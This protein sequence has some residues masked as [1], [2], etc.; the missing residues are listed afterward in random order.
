MDL[1]QNQEPAR[2]ENAAQLY[3]A[4]QT[5]LDHPEVREISY[6]WRKEGFYALGPDGQPVSRPRDPAA[7]RALDQ[8]L[9]DPLG[10]AN[11]FVSKVLNDC[12]PHLRNQV[13]WQG[14]RL[15]I[16]LDW[17]TKTTVFK[18]HFGIAAGSL[19]DLINAGREENPDP[20]DR[21]LVDAV[22]QALATARERMPEALARTRH[23]LET[24]VAPFGFRTSSELEGENEHL[25]LEPA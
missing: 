15:C 21:Y 25:Y 10:E 12:P 14:R 6:I 11:R 13:S 3:Q 22:T 17:I 18:A 23:E 20:T 9:W 7:R 16:S 5:A 4:L 2:I 1:I 19:E 24:A 8:A